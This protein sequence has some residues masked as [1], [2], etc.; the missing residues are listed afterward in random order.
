MVSLLQTLKHDEMLSNIACFGF[1]R[2]LCP[3][4]QA[5][6]QDPPREHPGGH[7]LS[8][9]Q[10]LRAVYGDREVKIVAVLREPGARLH[11]AFWQGASH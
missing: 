9:P 4:K 2:R 8:V 7:K 3:Y 10:L 5:V 11:A 1:N 6:A